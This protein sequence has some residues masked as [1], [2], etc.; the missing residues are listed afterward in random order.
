[1]EI[2][3]INRIIEFETNMKA[4]H[5]PSFASKVLSLSNTFMKWSALILA[6]I[7]SITTIITRVKILIIR[8]QRHPSL[9]SSQQQNTIDDDDDDDYDSETASSCSFSEDDEQEDEDEDDE[10]VRTSFRVDEDFCFRGSG[11]V[12]IDE[13]SCNR[14][15][16]LRRRRG[17]SIGDLFSWSEF[18]GGKSVVK[19]W[20][21][22]G[23]GLG[24][25]VSDDDDDE[26]EN[27]VVRGSRS[28]NLFAVYDMKS[29]RET[30]KI[31]SNFGAKREVPALVTTSSSS[32]AVTVAAAAEGGGRVV[33]RGWDSRI[34]SRIPAILAEWRPKLGKVIGVSAGGLDKVYVIDDVNIALTVGDMRKVNSPLEDLTET[35]ADTWWDAD[36]VVVTDEYF[37]ESISS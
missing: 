13:Q 3:V 1:M 18:T 15:M 8:L 10:T 19:L 28:G 7:A 27:D 14:N 21:N 2:P 25:D 30:E 35:E 36:A 9:A 34:G 24:F 20:D 37:H 5:N 6:L 29:D 22:L 12:Y 32:P 17:R 4:L 23:F 33:L 26:N 16:G 31:G 11:H